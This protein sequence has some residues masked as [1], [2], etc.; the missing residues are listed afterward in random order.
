M[1][2]ILVVSESH[3]SEIKKPTLE[4]LSHAKQMGLD[5][6]AVLIG[7]GVVGQAEVLAGYGARTV[8]LADDPSLGFHSTS[9]YTEIIHD[10]VSQS[11]ATQLWFSASESGADLMPRIAARLGVGA[12]SDVTQFSIEEHEITAR[13][14]AMSGKV[15]QECIF[16][17]DGIRVL[18]I[19]GGSYEI[20]PAE[21]ATANIVKMS[22]PEKDMRAVV[23][24]I[25]AETTEG[26]DLTEATV[27]VAVGRGV[28]GEEGIELVRP[29]A[30][31]LGAG[32]GAT[33]GVCDYGWMAHGAQIGQ[34]GKKVA[35]QIY[36]ALGISGAIQHLAGMIGSKLI[37]A[38][39]T[40]PEAP[41]F[42]VADYGIVGD[43]FKVVP[44]L[45]EEIKI[46]RSASA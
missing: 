21:P 31:L 23:R 4:L 5:T 25:V 15:I 46:I 24:E 20:G 18:S 35:P 39:N 6:S 12:I 32:Y 2:K 10:A 1:E 16:E 30:N 45:T 42:N 14:P 36:I 33:R 44:I 43:L 29:L 28:K 38:V 3:L 11:G 37:L 22:V 7:D 19:R 41:I 13:H 8:Y 9:V 26:I 17:K 40:D 34:T 27:V